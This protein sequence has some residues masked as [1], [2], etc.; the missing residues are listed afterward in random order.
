[1]ESISS[2]ALI[3]SY[4]YIKKSQDKCILDNNYDILEPF[5][6]IINLAIVSYMK[7][8]TKIAVNKNK[9]TLQKPKIYQGLVRM[10]KGHNREHIS[11]LLKPIIRFTELYPISED[12]HQIQY[13]E[14]LKLIAN[15][16]ILGLLK[17]K[18]NYQPTSTVCH[19]IDLYVS[20]LKSYSSNLVSNLNVGNTFSNEIDNLNL[21]IETKINI[22]SIFKN[23][24]NSNEIILIG[25]ILLNTDNLEDHESKNKINSIKNLLK[26][27]QPT[28][29]KIVNTAKN[30]F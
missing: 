9:I 13:N 17:L 30:L 12:E 26:S 21:S 25:S 29:D 5:S 14:S 23:I 6:V 28:I 4:K 15:R 18:N 3:K 27:K 22:D 19:S 2:F 20:L 10:T 11:Y 8:K 16:C 1:M 7:E 24:W